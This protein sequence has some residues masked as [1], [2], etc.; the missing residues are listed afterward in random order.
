MQCC[1]QCRIRA[2]TQDVN[3]DP[4]MLEKLPKGITFQGQVADFLP[5]GGA[6]SMRFSTA[7]TSHQHGR[8]ICSC[9]QT[10][11][12]E[13]AFGLSPDVPVRART[14]SRLHALCG[15][16][17]S[18]QSH[19]PEPSL[20]SGFDRIAVR[21]LRIEV[22]KKGLALMAEMP[23]VYCPAAWRGGISVVLSL[24]PRLRS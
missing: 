5:T 19:K 15:S 20:W 4:E 14:L 16:R 3:R 21:G 9:L 11:G 12:R 7:S 6:A 23:A 8:S 17:G 1:A 2:A 10:S 24:N 18:W 13:A 22:Q